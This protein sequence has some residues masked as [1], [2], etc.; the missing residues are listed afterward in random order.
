MAAPH[1][2][3]VKAAEGSTRMPAETFI[4][5]IKNESGGR[6][7]SVSIYADPERTYQYYTKTKDDKSRTGIA[8]FV[9]PYTGEITGN[10]K[11]ENGMREFMST[12]FS[13]HRWLLLDKIETPLFSRITNRELGSKITGWATIIFTLG[14]ITGMVIWVPQK[15]RNWKQGLKIKFNA[16]WKRVNHDLHN[17]L[18]FYSLFLLLLMGITGP[19]WSFDWYRTGLQK[20]LGTYTE[21]KEAPAKKE[22]ESEKVEVAPIASS[23]L[24]LST[25]IQV[26]DTKLNYTGDYRITLPEKGDSMVAFNKTKIG[27][28]A[29]AA[30]DKI[31]INGISGQPGKVDI[32]SNKP[33]NER[34]AGSIKAIHI[35]NSYGTFTK[36]LYFF[37]CLIATSLPVTGTLIWLNRLKKR[38]KKKFA[39]NASLKTKRSEEIVLG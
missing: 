4:E 19:Q 30:A 20:S 39:N 7:T 3:K 14:C 28:F 6:L 21:K 25:L 23:S 33:I 37:A 2:H 38:R 35:G 9:N 5:K 34:I 36:I 17:T 26:A 31:S 24:P 22:K 29:P 11:E 32:F 8:Y 12:M 1:L 27:F 18:A 13:L 10:S 16:N 15:V